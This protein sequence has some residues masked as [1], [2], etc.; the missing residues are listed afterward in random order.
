[1]L[2]ELI[3]LQFDEN[4]TIKE[5]YKEYEKLHAKYVYLSNTLTEDKLQEK[6]R[7]LKKEVHDLR[8][9]NENCETK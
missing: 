9:D 6:I 3:L 8:M 2:T 5:L 7:D 4:M 1:M